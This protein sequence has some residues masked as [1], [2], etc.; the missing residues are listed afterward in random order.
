MGLP[1]L[2]IKALNL[3]SDRI[4]EE[5]SNFQAIIYGLQTGI[6]YVNVVPEPVK[7]SV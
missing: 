6:R 5:N 3:V 7:C 4:L 1:S 2:K